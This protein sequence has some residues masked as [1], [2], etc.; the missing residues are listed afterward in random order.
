M[1]YICQQVGSPADIVSCPVE[2][3]LVLVYSGHAEI[4]D[5]R[6]NFIE[7]MIRTEACVDMEQMRIIHTN[8]N[9]CVKLVSYGLLSLFRF[10]FCAGGVF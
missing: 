2:S 3:T 5:S 6:R 9:I 4:D 8:G 10:F 7:A 1:L